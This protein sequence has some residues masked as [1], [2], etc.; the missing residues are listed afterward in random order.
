[1]SC[2]ALIPAR[3]GSAR[4]PGKNVKRLAG[5]PL[6]AYTISAAKESKIF[7][8]VIVSTEDLDTGLI[9]LDYGATWLD[10]PDDLATDTAPDI[11]WVRHALG[12]LPASVE[13][14]SL[15]RPTS[16][17]RTADTIRMA[18]AVWEQEGSR[19]DSLR[20]VR[21]VSE[22]PM[23]MWVVRDQA[24]VPLLGWSVVSEV[25]G[26]SQATQALPAVYVQ[27]SGLEIAWVRTVR[28]TETISGMRIRPF[29][30]LPHE[31][32]DINT[33]QDWE[34]AEDWVA[35]GVAKLP[36]IDGGIR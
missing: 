6:L 22:H 5:V 16:P 20:A 21:A 7:S 30:V 35:R 17:F 26:H 13:C 14:F 15:L 12:A 11:A 27:T 25:P 4:V 33:S 24:M 23:K 9:A 8:D 19:Y 10:R 1:M 28:E 32:H 36:T 18:W 34:L 3:S 2:V 29:H 31:G